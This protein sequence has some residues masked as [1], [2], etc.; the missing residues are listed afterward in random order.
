MSTSVTQKQMPSQREQYWSTVHLFIDTGRSPCKITLMPFA[1]ANNSTVI[2]RGLDGLFPFKSVSFSVITSKLPC[3]Q[4]QL[5][6]ILRVPCTSSHC[7]FDS[8]PKGP[9]PKVP[10]HV[11]YSRNIVKSCF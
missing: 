5:R 9:S 2:H 1:F 7:D 10:A 6:S 8:S 4:L 11:L 3:A